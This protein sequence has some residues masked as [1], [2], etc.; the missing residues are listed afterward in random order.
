[1]RMATGAEVWLL[2][3]LPTAVDEVSG[4]SSSWI[5][6]SCQSWGVGRGEGG[7]GCWAGD[8]RPP[9]LRPPT[10]W[11]HGRPDNPADNGP[12][13]CIIAQQHMHSLAW[14]SPCGFGGRSPASGLASHGCLGWLWWC[15]IPWLLPSHC[16]QSS[17]PALHGPRAA[18]S[19]RAPSC[20]RN[21]STSL[22]AGDHLQDT[23]SAAHHWSAPGCWRS[24]V[25]GCLGAPTAWQ[26]MTDGV[27]DGVTACSMWSP[28]ADTKCKT[29]RILFL[30]RKQLQ[31]G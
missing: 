12:L 26:T 9:S 30:Q 18:R 24:W 17:I 15:P 23:P 21:G 14:M 2:G 13:C 28:S 19:G 1:M 8:E 11:Q 22:G 3:T 6:W 27:I 31:G 29:G 20:S 4:R 7:K 16:C 5:L 10:P 25:A